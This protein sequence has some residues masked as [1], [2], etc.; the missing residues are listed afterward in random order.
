MKKFCMSTFCGNFL[1]F[2][3]GAY[4]QTGL[5]K[6][7]T[8]INNTVRLTTT[9]FLDI[10]EIF[11]ASNGTIFFTAIPNGTTTFTADLYYH[12]GVPGSTEVK[13]NINPSGEAG[14]SSIVEASGRLYFNAVDNGFNYQVFSLDIN[15]YSKYSWKRCQL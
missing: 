9:N 7:E 8:R 4:T 2:A 6:S 12:S 1:Y 10:E 3:A 5:F 14:V 13:V 11:E 15:N